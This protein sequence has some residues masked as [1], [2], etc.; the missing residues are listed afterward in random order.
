MRLRAE[1]GIELT[2]DL[3]D[4]W[5]A[6]VE[7]GFPGYTWTRV[8]PRTFKADS[9]PRPTRSIRIE[10][11]LWNIAVRRANAENSST[12]EIVRRAL[13]RYLASSLPGS[14]K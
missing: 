13:S 10:D 9:S 5:S 6:D 8:D 12:S 11:D 2:E 3:I 4:Q 14:S 7:A 1:T